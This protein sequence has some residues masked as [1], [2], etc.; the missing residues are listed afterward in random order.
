MTLHRWV[1]KSDYHVAASHTRRFQSSSKPQKLHNLY[2]FKTLNT[3][4]VDNSWIRSVTRE[5]DEGLTGSNRPNPVKKE[6]DAAMD[7]G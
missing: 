5:G 6:L 7:Y 2:Y 1:I 3:R 4:N